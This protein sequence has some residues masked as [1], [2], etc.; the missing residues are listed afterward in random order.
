MNQLNHHKIVLLLSAVLLCFNTV[1]GQIGGSYTYGLL[2]L[3]TSARSGALGG[4]LIAVTDPDVSVVN[5]NPAFLGLGIDNQLSLNYVNYF[6]DI[7]YGRVEY[8]HGTKKLGT[9]SAGLFYLNYGDFMKPMSMVTLPANFR[10]QNILLIFPGAT[11]L[12][13][14]YQLVC[15]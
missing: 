1:H 14:F 7:N 2:N 6:A 12:T 13:V 4:A 9:F 5:E 11:V 8:A 10:Q 3:N 15:R